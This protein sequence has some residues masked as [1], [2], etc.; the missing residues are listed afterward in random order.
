MQVPGNTLL[1]NIHETILV[2]EQVGLVIVMREAHTVGNCG[3]TQSKEEPLGGFE[4][5]SDGF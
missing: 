4:L 2:A 1:N 3:E 5:V